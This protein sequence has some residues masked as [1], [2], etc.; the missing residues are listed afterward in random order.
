MN[1]LKELIKNFVFEEQQLNEQIIY[2]QKTAD[3]Y[4]KEYQDE[5]SYNQQLQTENTRLEAELKQYKDK[6]S[7]LEKSITNKERI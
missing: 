1:E 3:H 4:K 2:L 7:I 5:Y 6:V